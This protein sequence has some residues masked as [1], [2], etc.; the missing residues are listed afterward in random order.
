MSREISEYKKRFDILV[1]SEIGNV[2]PILSE[3]IM[4][5]NW[6]KPDDTL[7]YWK[8]LYDTLSK[9]PVK[10]KWQ[11]TNDPKKSNYITYGNWTIYKDLLQN[12]GYPIVFNDTNNQKKYFKFAKN[13]YKGEPLSNISITSKK[14]GKTSK[15]SDFLKT[16][17]TKIDTCNPKNAPKDSHPIVK[18]ALTI[19]YN[20]KGKYGPKYHED[21]SKKL[22]NVLIR[23]NNNDLKKTWGQLNEFQWGKLAQSKNFRICYQTMVGTDTQNGWDKVRHFIYTGYLRLSGN[24]YRGDGRISSKLFTYGKEA[25][26]EMESWFGKDPEGWSEADISADKAGEAFAV[27]TF[28]KYRK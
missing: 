19:L 12:S 14:T 23:K 26:D 20:D 5:L 27:Y 28:K 2:K 9:A 6:K 13:T 1:E 11:V 25:W 8:N 16:P 15:L 7:G 24:I 10:P 22:F 3:T 21:F 17:K 4:S 18:D